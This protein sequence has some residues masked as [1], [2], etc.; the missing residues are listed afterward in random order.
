MRRVN[1]KK[2]QQEEFRLSSGKDPWYEYLKMDYY[3]QSRVKFINYE[4]K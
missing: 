3:N 1:A 2:V 4:L